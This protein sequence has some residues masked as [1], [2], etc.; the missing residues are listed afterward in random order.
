MIRSFEEIYAELK[1]IED[2][3]HIF[4]ETPVGVAT[5]GRFGGEC[6]DIYKCTKCGYECFDDK[7]YESIG[8]NYNDDGRIKG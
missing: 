6:L 5:I 2:C 3:E 7:E 1:E 4:D 8:N